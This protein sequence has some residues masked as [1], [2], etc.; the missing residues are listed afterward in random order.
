MTVSPE[1]KL[2]LRGSHEGVKRLSLRGALAEH[3]RALPSLLHHQI[4]SRKQW[5]PHE[6]QRSPLWCEIQPSGRR[7]AS[8]LQIRP[9]GESPVGGAG[10]LVRGL[11]LP[12]SVFWGCSNL[13]DS[14]LPLAHPQSIPF[15]NFPTARTNGSWEEGT[16]RLVREH[17]GSRS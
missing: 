10:I 14:P 15:Q 6:P 1:S 17:P 12:P 9:R 8:H 2:G 4:P 11:A 5:L 16:S 7:K 13:E 3:P